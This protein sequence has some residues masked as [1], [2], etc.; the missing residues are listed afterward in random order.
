MS[1]SRLAQLL[2]RGLMALG[3]GVGALA[4]GL[5]VFD[6]RIDIPAWM[7]RVAVVKLTLAGALGMI[8]TGAA[9][10]RHLRRGEQRDLVRRTPDEQLPE[11]NW[12]SAVRP[13]EADA[14]VRTSNSSR[15]P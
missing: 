15:T 2:A 12:N 4:M 8:V 7:W 9:L 14:V 13:R 5:W 3:L 11:P 6:I 1:G 10:L